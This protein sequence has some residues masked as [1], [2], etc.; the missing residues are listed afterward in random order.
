[1][2][3]VLSKSQFNFSDAPGRSVHFHTW[4]EDQRHLIAKC[5]MKNYDIVSI[6]FVDRLP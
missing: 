5:E 4:T 6:E 3:V 2:R 1:M